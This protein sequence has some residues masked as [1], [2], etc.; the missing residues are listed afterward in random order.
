MQTRPEHWNE[1]YEAREETALTW[2]EAEPTLSLALIE[3]CSGPGDAIIDIG[4]GA[5]RLVDALV[6]DGYRAVTVL[7]VS[8]AALRQSRNRLGLRADAVTWIEADIAQWRPENA[9]AVWH[10]RAVFHFLTE[11]ADRAAYVAAMSAAVLPGGTAI[12]A[13][14]AED[15]PERCSG[16]PVVRYAPADL[17]A[18]IEALAPGVFEP[19]EAQRHEHATPKGARQM[20]QVSVFRK[21]A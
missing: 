8:Q 20:F 10:D 9:Y 18:T 21:S 11:P 3:A 15:G 6:A 4:G 1:V 17:A 7:D 13:T 12:I 16:L 14:F 19:L 5:S 2:F